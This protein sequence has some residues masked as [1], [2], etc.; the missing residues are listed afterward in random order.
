M[1]SAPGMP[2]EVPALPVYRGDP[3][4][5][6]FQFVD[7]DTTSGWTFTA[8]VRW[9]PNAEEVLA[10]LTVDLAVG[11]DPEV[12]QISLTEDDTA[13]LPPGTLYWDMQ[14]DEDKRTYLKGSLI[15]DPD[16]TRATA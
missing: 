13:L 3:F 12:I 1:D 5:Q 6:L 4:A 7:Q 9:Y 11:G 15:V 10:E 16:V 8:Q 14:R 2:G